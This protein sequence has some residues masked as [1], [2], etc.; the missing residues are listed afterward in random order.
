M[1]EKR[2]KLAQLMAAVMKMNT[3]KKNNCFLPS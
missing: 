3:H 2:D 1:H